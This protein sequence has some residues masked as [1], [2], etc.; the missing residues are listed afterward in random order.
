MRRRR[1]AYH[2][3]LVGVLLPAEEE[4]R[5]PDPRL[6]SNFAIQLLGALFRDVLLVRRGHPHPTDLD[7]RSLAAETVRALLAYLRASS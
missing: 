5:H 3:R 4:I 6:A 1:A 2:E 7:E